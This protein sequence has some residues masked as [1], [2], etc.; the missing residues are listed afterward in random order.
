MS[1]GKKIREARKSRGLTQQELERRSGV[2]RNFISQVENDRKGISM[3]RLQKLAEALGMPLW[4]LMGD[5]DHRL[6]PVINIAA[7]GMWEDLTDLD[8]PAGVADRYELSGS[9]DP[10]AFYVVASGD[11]MIGGDIR[12]GDL[13]LVEPNKEVRNGDIVLAK[14]P[15]LGVTVKKFYMKNGNVVLVS[16]NDRYPPLTPR[17]DERFRVYRVTEQRR[18]L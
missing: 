9:R 2:S 8:Y 4:Q 5:D 7:C 16:L 6:I 15:E 17:R 14:D 10:N 3:A 18:K 11:S 12:E 13:L 1:I